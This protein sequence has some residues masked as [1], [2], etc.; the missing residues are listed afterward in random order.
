MRVRARKLLAC[1]AVAA[2]L[3][4][5]FALYAQRNAEE[6]RGTQRNAEERRGRKGYAE[7]AENIRLF[8]IFFADSA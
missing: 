6:R 7:D 5:V 8:C 2:V 1:A 3:A 4:G